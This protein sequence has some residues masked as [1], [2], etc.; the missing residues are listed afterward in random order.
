MKKI[1]FVLVFFL[2]FPLVC[3]AESNAEV[4]SITFKE[5]S[6]NTKVVSEATTDGEKINLDLIFYD[7]GDY[8]TY[9]VVVENK[10]SEKLFINGNIFKSDDN[11]ISYEFSYD[12]N[13]NYINPGEE[14]IITLK[15]V[16]SKAIEKEEFGSGGLYEASTTEP[17]I[18]SNKLISIP[19]TLKNLGPLGV[20]FIIAVI[21][22]IIVG[23][24]ISI[25]NI[26][27]KEVLT[28]IIGIALFTIPYIASALLMVEIPV[29]ATITIKKVKDN[30][31]TFEGT[32]NAGAT[33]VNGQYTYKYKQELAAATWTDMEDD[34]WGM[35][36][37]DKDS[38]DPVTSKMC[39]SINGK[40]IV[41]MSAIFY[42]AKTSKVDF[43]SFDTSN[44]NDFSGFFTYGAPNATEIELKDIEYLDTSKVTLFS[45]LFAEFGKG[46]TVPII[47]D[48]TKW[49]THSVTNTY[50]MFVN[51]GMNSAGVDLNIS[52]WD[53]SND[54]DVRVAF[55][56]I[57]DSATGEVNINLSNIKLD[58]PAI[59]SINNVF[60]YSGWGA[61][62]TTLNVSNMKFKA[63][64]I[65][66]MEALFREVGYDGDTTIDMTG[67]STTGVTN[68]KGIFF[69]AG[70][71]H[72][73][74][75]K[76]LEGIDLSSATDT[77]SM[78]STIKNVKLDGLRI[79]A[80]NI[81]YMFAGSVNVYGSIILTGEPTDY[82]D[83]FVGTSNDED[84]VLT[85][86]YASSVTSIESIIA[87]KGENQYIVK[88]SQIDS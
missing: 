9:D 37:T 55:R 19:N 46:A 70:A 7:Q 16:Y 84:H 74:T 2:M 56:C 31:C 8:A 49:D 15:A 61:P 30:P 54:T 12:G 72:N 38:T 32:L 20:L 42:Y 43:S 33:Y 21:A 53:L 45:A 51:F 40:P 59:T 85:V 3:F 76:G 4:K 83:I 79:P 48:L 63:G 26:K 22:C 18:L 11:H 28:L 64:N 36:L 86:N 71:N 80:T 81:N 14:Q 1:M 67:W 6:E 27:N 44:V 41:S 13:K 23:L 52:G 62:K 77:N 73:L 25:K 57:G 50:G 10:A 65:T 47:L 82:T 68:M 78:F 75:L 29:E 17:L 58:N 39:T 5:K 35:A 87:T 34:G 88:G 69:K 24:Y 66:D 60:A